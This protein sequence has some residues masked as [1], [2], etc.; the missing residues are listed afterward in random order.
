[1]LEWFRSYLTGRT[2]RVL[3][4]GVKSPARTAEYGVPHCSV[5]RPLLFVPYTADL[6]LIAHWHSVEAHFYVDDSLMY[7]FSKPSDS[8]TPEDRLLSCLDD[9]SVWMKS[10]HVSFNPSETQVMQCVTSRRQGQLNTAP[11]EFY[12]EK[13]YPET[14]V[15]NLGVIIDSFV[16]FQPHISSVVSSCF[17]QLRRMKS[18]LKLLPFDIART[19]I[20]SFVISTI[21]YC[22][23]LLANSS[24][25]ALNWLQRVIHS[26]ARLVCHSARLTPISGLLCNRLH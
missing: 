21:D 25:H 5:L 10:I 17:Y 1:M 18:S 11:I 13:I 20:N 9:I 23:C 14:S 12:N 16:M 3:F 4:R 6:E 19:V 22:N 8:M 26:A 2:E 7:I 15:H 24:Q